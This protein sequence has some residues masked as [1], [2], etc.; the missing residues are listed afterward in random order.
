MATSLT[1]FIRDGYPT[2][3]SCVIDVSFTVTYAAS[4][5]TRFD[6]YQNGSLVST[7]W[8]STYALPAGGSKDNL[9]KTFN[10]LLPD[11]DYEIVAELYNAT[12][13]AGLGVTDSVSFTTDSEPVPERPANWQ[14]SS[15]VAVNA[16][17]PVTQ[18]ADGTYLAKYLTAAEWDG[19]I[20]R[21]IA[22][23][24]YLG[25]SVSGSQISAT[26]GTNMEASDV[27]AVIDL[28]TIMDPPT[29]PPA[30]VATGDV[31]SAA[32]V[33]GLKNSLNS[34]T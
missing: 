3:S 27:N 4:Y 17:V 5:K 22:F 18:A 23:A 26:P 8:G 6:L 14:W 10:G 31:I 19:F 1:I 12:T 20:A 13:N 21:C 2:Y 34:I 29:S 28:L 24:K 9:R 32:T 16:A 7:S 15:T 11:T 30:K 33:N 25:M